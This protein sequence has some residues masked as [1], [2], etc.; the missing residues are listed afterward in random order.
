MS[1]Y[2]TSLSCI[3]SLFLKPLR[4]RI[5]LFCRLLFTHLLCCV[6]M[7]QL[8]LQSTNSSPLL[9]IV[10]DWRILADQEPCV[11]SRR[12]MLTFKHPWA[13]VP[14]LLCAQRASTIGSELCVVAVGECWDCGQRVRLMGSCWGRQRRQ[15]LLAGAG[16][17][18]V[19]GGA[20]DVCGGEQ[21]GSTTRYS[22][23][24]S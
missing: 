15:V 20:A 21:S 24:R 18:F 13:L 22:R 1:C 6:H 7:W 4:V 5:F 10:I 3:V 23:C 9:H 8:L 2:V 14:S 11:T 12:R 19:S 16:C 17:A